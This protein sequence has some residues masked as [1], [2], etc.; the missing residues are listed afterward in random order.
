MRAMGRKLALGV[1]LLVAGT[2]VGTLA[3]SETRAAGPTFDTPTATATL[4]NP[5]SFSVVV[6]GSTTPDVELVTSIPA[7]TDTFVEEATVTDQGA[8]TYQAT[9]EESGHEDPNTTLDYHFRT[10]T[11]DGSEV[12]SAK[13]SVTVVD[14][15][16]SWQELDGPIVRLHWYDGDQ[17]FAQRALD[18]G[19]KGIATASALL[20][21]TETEPVDFFV[22]S[23][24]APFRDALGPGTREN[25]GGEAVAD[26]RTLFALIEPDQID[27][28]WVGIVI[29]HELTH[30]V[31]N[32]AVSNPYHD[33]PRWLNEGL[34]VYLSAGDADTD[35]AAVASAVASNEL[36]P[37]SGLVGQFP[38]S[39]D[40]FSLAYSESVSAVDYF[41]TTY[42]KADLAALIRSYATGVTD[43]EAFTAAIGQDVEA[44]DAA[45]QKSVGASTPQPYG[46]RPAPAGPA[47]SGW[48]TASPE[49]SPTPLVP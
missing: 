34:A 37:L 5:V 39:A 38:T 17:A 16:F 35:K 10:Y 33:P 12:D 48:T 31:F 27:Q 1:A 13:A 44:F 26:I 3:V 14:D 29:P 28:A 41:V 8:G 36:I 6:H 43:D 21:V 24:E 19:E 11:S 45:W 22:Y 42:G 46:P 25:V 2:V 47:P 40:R 23:S 7:S 18:V 9:V 4:D 30:L 32:T 15:R 20:G 49:P